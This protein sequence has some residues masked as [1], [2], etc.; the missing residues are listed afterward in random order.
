MLNMSRCLVAKQ[1]STDHDSR[2]GFMRRQSS[3]AWSDRKLVH[4]KPILES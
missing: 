4:I 1:E 3:R 2:I